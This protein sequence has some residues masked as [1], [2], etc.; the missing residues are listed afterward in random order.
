MA[1]YRQ[2]NFISKKPYST[3][4]KNW[5]AAALATSLPSKKGRPPPGDAPI[6]GRPQ[7]ALIFG[8]YDKHL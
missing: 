1:G 3:Q 2:S 8:L 6:H 4:W 5:S 7:F